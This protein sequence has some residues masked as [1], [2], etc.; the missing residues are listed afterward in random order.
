IRVVTITRE[1]DAPVDRVYRAWEDAAIVAQWMGPDDGTI[2]I[3][4]WDCR[5]G[6]SY[7]YTHRFGA[8]TADFFG[9]FHE[10]RPGERLVQTFTFCGVPAA[11]CRV[12]LTFVDLPDGRCRIESIGV[13]DSLQAPAGIMA[14]GMEVG[15]NDGDAKLDALLA[16]G[17]VAGPRTPAR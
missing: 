16:G 1:F 4:T 12:T 14:S 11:V 9:S 13:V 8:E 15:I 6:G 7:R 17:T 2:Q 10:A 5:T 3:D